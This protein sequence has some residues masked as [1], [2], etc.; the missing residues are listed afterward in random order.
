MSFIG[1]Q[2]VT[3]SIPYVNIDV[4]ESEDEV[5][6]GKGKLTGYFISNLAASVMYVK[7]FDGTAADVTVGTTVPRYIFALQPRTS[8]NDHGLELEF[9]EGLT[10]AAVTGVRDDSTTGPGANEVVVSFSYRPE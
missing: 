1:G 3:G 5:F 4:D 9:F 10:I 7:L 2:L 8:A 6:A